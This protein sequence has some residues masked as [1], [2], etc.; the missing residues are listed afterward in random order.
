MKSALR[1]ELPL[2]AARH[3]TL[4]VLAMLAGSAAHAQST[5]FTYQGKLED[6]G[7][8]SNGL[9]DFRF[10]LFNMETGGVVV[11][12]LN[13]VDDVDVVDGVFTVQLDFGAVYANGERHVEVDVRKDTG[14][15]CAD[16]TGFVV[17]SPRQEITVAPVAVHANAA[18]V[19]DA[20]DGVPASAVYVD[21]AGKVG[22]GTT[23]PATLVHL[24]G[25]GPVMILQDTASATNQAG[26]VGFWNNASTETGW[27][28][29][30]S[31][32]IPDFSIVNSRSGGDINLLPG[33]GGIG[34][35]TTSP[36]A[37]LDVRGDIKLGS[38]GELHATSGGEKLRIVRGRVLSGGSLSLG[39][40]FTSSR[41][42]TGTY[43][44]AFTTPFPSTPVVTVSG[45]VPAIGGPF[46]A[47]TNGVT[48]LVAGVRITN[49]SGTSV[50]SAFDFIAIGVR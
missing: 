14:I 31:P 19:L 17:L 3:V 41:T 34:I 35:G 11:G 50:D 27:I 10:R 22:I 12:P 38:S 30:G 42:G 49:G 40:G 29:Y 44:V 8:P 15:T 24:Q 45:S 6:A 37:K 25:T 26:Y 32:G 47:H 33:T 18:F 36:T 21:H 43:T 7:V 48:T 13:C 20:A 28:G 1:K 46:I 4:V 9:H 5:T 16:G 2:Q 39:S 23:S